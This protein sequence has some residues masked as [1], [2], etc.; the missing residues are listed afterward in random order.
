MF[1]RL[2]RSSVADIFAEIALVLWL[3]TSSDTICDKIFADVLLFVCVNIP[4]FS[5]FCSL[6]VNTIVESFAIIKLVC[7]CRVIL[8]SM[9]QLWVFSTQMMGLEL[10]KL[11]IKV[12]YSTWSFKLTWTFNLHVVGVW[13]C[14]RV[15]ICVLAVKVH[16]YREL[17]S[18]LRYCKL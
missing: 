10:G 13:A 15:C 18:V 11:F 3:Y 5:C 17:T 8:A 14:V 7:K 12:V 9:Y 2:I 16:I 6:F 1:I 4:L